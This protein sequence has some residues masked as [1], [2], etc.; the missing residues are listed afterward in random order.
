MLAL[1]EASQAALFEKISRAFF[2]TVGMPNVL[3]GCMLSLKDHFSCKCSLMEDY[4]TSKDLS[5]SLTSAQNCRFV[6][7]YTVIADS[8]RTAQH[9]RT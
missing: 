9:S 4:K 8:V 7:L 6:V 1:N 2:S 5:A 3:A